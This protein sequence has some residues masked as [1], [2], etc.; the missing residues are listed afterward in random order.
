MS[1]L[2]PRLILVLGK[3]CFAH[4]K[5][6]DKDCLE[7]GNRKGLQL[8]RRYG[9]WCH[10]ILNRQPLAKTCIE[11]AVAERRQNSG[12]HKDIDQPRLPHLG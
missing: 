11:F 3:R 1:G 6:E 4:S 12:D 10:P 9:G 5:P 2:S 8:F 7:T